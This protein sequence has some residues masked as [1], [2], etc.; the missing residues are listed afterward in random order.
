MLK[1]HT[2]TQQ[3]SS[4]EILSVERAK[5]NKITLKINDETYDVSMEF[6]QKAADAYVTETKYEL[7]TEDHFKTYYSYDD[8][9]RLVNKSCGGLT[10]N[11]QYLTYGYNNVTYQSEILKKV[12]VRTSDNVLQYEYY[13]TFDGRGNVTRVCDGCYTKDYTYDVLDRITAEKVT[14]GNNVIDKY[15]QYSYNNNGQLLGVYDLLND[16]VL[17]SFTYSG[18]KLASVTANDSTSYYSYD[19]YGNIQ[20]IQTGNI[21]ETLAWI[22]GNFLKQKGA[23]TYTYNHL[24]VRTGKSNTTGYNVTYYN[25]GGKLLGDYI[26]DGVT[27]TSIRYFYDITGIAGF[28][29][30]N[31]DYYYGKDALGNVRKIIRATDN[32]I[33]G[34][35]EYDA[36]GKITNS[37]T[38]IAQM[39]TIRWKGY[40]RDDE[41]GWYYINGRYYDPNIGQY[42]TVSA[43]EEL[44][45]NVGLQ[46]WNRYLFSYNNALSIAGNLNNINFNGIAFTPDYWLA[47]D[48]GLPSWLQY[49]LL[50]L[51]VISLIVVAIINPGAIP[52]IL[53]AAA[54][55]AIIAFTLTFI[56][57]GTMAA[58]GRMRWSK[59]LEMSAITALNAFA[60]T[61]LTL[62]I[63]TIAEAVAA[64]TY[65]NALSVS[66]PETG[67][68]TPT[69]S[70]PK[71]NID[72][73]FTEWLNKGENN[74]SVYKGIRKSDEV[75]TGITKQPISKRL[76]QHNRA[77]KNFNRLETINSNLTRNQARAIET[78]KI[79]TDGTSAEN[80]ILS[81]SRKHRYFNQAMDWAKIFLGG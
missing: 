26:N 5:P 4:D 37:L 58:I 56:V 7:E 10:T 6:E 17:K 30:N 39:N 9:G 70:S 21:T 68:A 71:T 36:F 45:N 74:Y 61:V 16:A 31:T 60:F 43:A 55:N 22:R 3:N 2:M 19:Y 51:A 18:G 44:L 29:Y 80:I 54:C 79:L 64:A 35:Y 40:Y 14:N 28:R 63:L 38:S 75:Y 32:S 27:V 73:G 52:Y 59:A 20:S 72:N 47:I 81:I 62:S 46:S 50:P 24:G 67:V 12:E 15:V 33:V 8:L 42:I 57:T 77:G 66:Q 48:W 69:A 78:Y 41:S 1:K 25:V 23:F 65:T 13:N 34:S 53:S 49:V 76:A 11:Y